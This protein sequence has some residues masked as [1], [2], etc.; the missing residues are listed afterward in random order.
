MKLRLKKIAAYI[1]WPF[2]WLGCEIFYYTYCIWP[3]LKEYRF[4]TKGSIEDL[5]RGFSKIRYYGK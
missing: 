3:A 2:I 5:K 1:I 4:N